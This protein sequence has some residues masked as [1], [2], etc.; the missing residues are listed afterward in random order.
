LRPGGAIEELI[1]LAKDI[2][3]A[4]ARGEETGLMDEE[5][6]F[7][8][9]LAENESARQVIGRTSVAGHRPRI[10][11][12]HQEQCLGGLDAPGCGAC[13]DAGSGE[14]S[15]SQIR[16]PAR[17][18]ACGGTVC[19]RLRR[20]RQIGRRDPVPARQGVIPQRAIAREVFALNETRRPGHTVRGEVACVRKPRRPR[21]ST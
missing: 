5:I 12:E 17:L 3:A 18:A 21:A 6:A 1:Q 9:A 8:D 13:P 10:G 16:L 7:Y 4:R 15:A 14:A 19:N 20:C 2:R 11:G